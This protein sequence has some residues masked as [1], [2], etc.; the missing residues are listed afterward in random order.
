MKLLLTLIVILSSIGSAWSLD[1][2]ISPWIRKVCDNNSSCLPTQIDA[3]RFVQLPEPKEESFSAT[4]IEFNQF[5]V[6]IIWS[7]S[8]KSGGYYGLQTEVFNRDGNPI[9]LCSKYESLETFELKVV[10]ACG[11]ASENSGELLGVSYLIP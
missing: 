9:A 7:K 3:S 1:F 6:R 11:G 5:S 2:K 8:L 10:G 4:T